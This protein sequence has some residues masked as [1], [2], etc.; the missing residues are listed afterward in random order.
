MPNPMYQ[1]LSDLYA[2]MQTDS[3]TAGHALQDA[4]QRM[5]GGKVWT[6]PA[7]GTWNGNL[8][9]YSSDLARQV[10]QTIAAVRQ[11]LASTPQ[12]VSPAEALIMSKLLAGRPG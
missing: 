1:A 5:T 4:C 2:S 8:T 10:D 6:G 9:G 7:A 3:G 12:H 11:A